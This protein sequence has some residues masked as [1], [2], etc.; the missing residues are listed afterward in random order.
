MSLPR[1]KTIK[2]TK[3]GRPVSAS[4]NLPLCK[5]YTHAGSTTT[6]AITQSNLRIQRLRVRFWTAGSVITV[7]LTGREQPAV[8]MTLK[9]D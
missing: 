1:D 2:N 9:P 5:P 8:P 6:N 4:I 7:Q 3:T